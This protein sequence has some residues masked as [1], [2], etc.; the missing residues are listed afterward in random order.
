MKLAYLPK[1]WRAL[2]VALPQVQRAFFKQVKFL[3]KDLR[4]PSLQAK[5]YDE[6]NDLWQARVNRDLG[7]HLKTGHSW[8]PQNR[9]LSTTRGTDV[10][11]PLPVGEASAFSV[12]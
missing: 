12:V 7:G 10:F 6:T 5:K 3:E 4:H 2:E 11:T 1:A 8:P 9:P